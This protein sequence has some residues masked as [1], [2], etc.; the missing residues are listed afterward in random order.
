MTKRDESVFAKAFENMEAEGCFEGLR[1][2]PGL[3]AQAKPAANAR[4][5]IKAGKKPRQKAVASVSGGNAGKKVSLVA[6]RK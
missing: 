6:S 3:N 1:A 4:S 2:R 5:V